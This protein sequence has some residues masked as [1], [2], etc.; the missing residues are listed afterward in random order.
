MQRFQLVET[1]PARKFQLTKDPT[2]WQA[3]SLEIAISDHP[4]LLEMVLGLIESFGIRIK[5]RVSALVAT[6]R[7][8]NHTLT[9]VDRTS[10]DGE[11]ESWTYFSL[12]NIDDE[13][14]EKF[15][16]ILEKNLTDLQQMVADFPAQKL[17][18][19]STLTD[20]R[21]H[22]DRSWLLDNLIWMGLAKID[23]AGQLTEPLGILKNS[24]L[25]NQ[26]LLWFQD[27]SPQFQAGITVYESKIA[28][29]VQRRKPLL[30]LTIA[31]DA[32]AS[33][34]LVVVGSFAS[35]GE[36]SQRFSIPQIKRKIEEIAAELRI[37]VRSHY[38]RELY[39]LSQLVPLG[40]LFT[41]P[42]SFWKEWFGFLLERQNQDVAAY[43]T[44]L[45]PIYGGC[46]LIRTVFD[47]GEV[48]AALRSFCKKNQIERRSVIHRH[49]EGIQYEFLW[50]VNKDGG[51]SIQQLL[52]EHNGRLLRSYSDRLLSL[53]ADRYSD[54]QVIRERSGMILGT[55]TDDAQLHLTPA[56]YFEGL[57]ILEKQ[58]ESF[59][60]QYQSDPL[61]GFHV[62]S[63]TAKLLS[64]MTPAFDSCGIPIMHVIRLQF[65]IAGE[66][67]YRYIFFVVDPLP[68]D[69]AVTLCEVLSG[70]LNGQ[71]TVDLTNRLVRRPEFHLRRLILLKALL[72]C[73]Y[74]MD[75]S[76]SRTFLMNTMVNH[77]DLTL[78]MLQYIEATFS[79]DDPEIR[80]KEQATFIA[81]IDEQITNLRTLR[82]REAGTELKELV[83][84]IVRTNALLDEPDV[85]FKIES[86]RLS[87]ISE[88]RPMFEIFVYSL[89]FEGVHLRFGPVSRGGIRWSNR[90]D[91]FRVEIVGLVHTQ[92]I[93]NTII[94]PEGS[95]GGFIL[96]T[97]VLTGRAA[98][99]RFMSALLRVTDNYLG[100][101]EVR[102]QGLVCLDPFDPYLVVAAD[103]GT[104]KFSDTANEV[105]NSQSFWVGDAFASGG[106]N[107]YDHKELGITA[108]GTWESVKAHF[109]ELNINPEKDLIRCVGIGGMSGDVFGN[110][111]LLSDRIKLI[112]AFNHRYIFLDPNPD[113]DTSFKERKRLFEAGL[114]WESY[115]KEL[116]S[117]GGDIVEKDRADLVVSSQVRAALGIKK[118]KITGDELIKSILCADVDLLWNGG[119]GTYVKS[120]KERN[121]QIG[122]QSNDSVRVNGCDLKAKVIGEGGN[123]GFSMQG[124]YEAAKAGVRLN[125]DAVDNSGGVDMSDHEVNLKIL[126]KD[127]LSRGLVASNDA[128]NKIIRDLE[129]I[130]IE[131]V[132]NNNRLINRCIKME[133]IRLRQDSSTLPLWLAELREFGAFENHQLPDDIRTLY[134]PLIGN[135]VGWSKLYYL[136]NIVIDGSSDQYLPFIIDRFRGI[137][138]DDDVLTN[139]V[140]N[141][142]LCDA[143]AKTEVINHIVHHSGPTFLFRMQHQL[144]LSLEEIIEKRLRIERWFDAA[145]LRKQAA[146]LGVERLFELETMLERALFAVHL[147]AD[148]DKKPLSS[149]IKSIQSYDEMLNQAR[150]FLLRLNSGQLDAAI[151]CMNELHVD[152]LEHAIR[153]NSVYEI[154]EMRFQGRMLLQLERIRTLAV[155]EQVDGHSM[156]HLMKSMKEAR[157]LIEEHSGGASIALFEHFGEILEKQLSPTQQA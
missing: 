33:H 24:S 140:K 36:L 138:V 94:V 122:D 127:M 88:P 25:Q 117:E 118:E 79:N 100:G 93:K 133:Q 128:R 85:S 26:I 108:K 119:I 47:G 7:D 75:R 139:C 82:E 130:M 89:D 40:L 53:I 41:R 58:T 129:P 13:I 134:S 141:H 109:A 67:V 49:N 98:Y 137:P 116:L 142:P 63:R 101:A 151:R 77:S 38:W 123:L 48:A 57:L 50:L 153:L 6:K 78:A 145:T 4:F 70:I 45:D 154:T 2:F 27:T 17:A 3:D 83:F 29:E 65:E 92:R 34:R 23:K 114:S 155:D 62:F 103:R 113:P 66:K 90:N 54:M 32:A 8:E 55:L 97:D 37:R 106:S 95:K 126:L 9:A 5:F 99:R 135:L 42:V 22:E 35:K 96:K 14:R 18:V 149:E 71:T 39:R 19:E 28:N 136:S 64:E 11:F 111:M 87:F 81:K 104:A 91:D 146:V 16:S 148:F 105:S 86:R 115:S 156:T 1:L 21:F 43:T 131:Q 121:E 15:H 157:R 84:A 20:A 76:F 143:I 73:L 59:Q 74:Q 69:Q 61:P 52:L 110:G 147:V 31:S 152:E 12:S 107:G 72:A 44:L 30:I 112:A 124:R 120:S 144:G 132:L 60:V 10:I 46:W 125:T 51:E 150:F 56:Q 68:D 102:P 80:Q